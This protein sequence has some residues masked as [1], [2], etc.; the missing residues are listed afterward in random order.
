MVWGRGRRRAA[1]PGGALRSCA[2][3]AR[4]VWLGPAAGRPS[5][6]RRRAPGSA[7]GPRPER[8]QVCGGALHISIGLER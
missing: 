3:G 1:G 8:R 7:S 6:R 5:G 2:G 4:L